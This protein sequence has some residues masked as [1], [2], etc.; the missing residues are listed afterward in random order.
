MKDRSYLHKVYTRLSSSKGKP[1]LSSK[2]RTKSVIRSLSNAH[3]IRQ[4]S[5][6]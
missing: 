2:R 4:R 6:G 3:E 1:A 5:V